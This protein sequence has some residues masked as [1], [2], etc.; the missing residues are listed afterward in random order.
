[1]AKFYNYEQVKKLHIQKEL[2]EI[3]Y[4][5]YH[6]EDIWDVGDE[7]LLD[8][9]TRH[10][11]QLARKT[12]EKSLKYDYC[13]YEDLLDVQSLLWHELE[14][15]LVQLEPAFH[16]LMYIRDKCSS[17]IEFHPECNAI[18]T[19]VHFDNSD[20]KI[21]IG[22][23]YYDNL[24]LDD[25]MTVVINKDEPKRNIPFNFIKDMVE[26]IKNN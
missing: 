12:I 13:Y 7:Y 4:R 10:N 15:T 23:H 9:E 21:N 26:Y 6:F 20:N 14:E 11:L 17:T 2:A 19:T 24:K 5:I 25:H 22:I 18:M 3:N 16:E 8:D 1:M